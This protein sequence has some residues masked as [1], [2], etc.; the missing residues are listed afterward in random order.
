M[1]MLLSGCIF[2]GGDI[3]ETKVIEPYYILST[4]SNHQL[5]AK[6]NGASTNKVIVSSDIDSI[7]HYDKFIFGKTGS[8]YFIFSTET[9]KF[10][11]E[12]NNPS[13]FKEAKE[14]LNLYSEMESTY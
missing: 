8:R 5:I 6:E 1:L 4:G 10:Y 9:Q 3:E 11:G 12:Y 14:K 7:G 2:S 13:L